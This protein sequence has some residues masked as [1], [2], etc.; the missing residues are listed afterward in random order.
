MASVAHGAR[1]GLAGDWTIVAR[2]ELRDLWL[3]GRGLPLALAF[4]VLLSAIAY[5]GATNEGLNFLER[6]ETVNLVAQVAVAMGAML[7]VLVAADAISG[8]RERG[9]LESLLLTPVSRRGLVAGKLLAALSLW[10]AALVVALPYLWF[11]ARGVGALGDAVGAAL[12]AGTLVAVALA[13]LGLVVSTLAGSNRLSLSVSLFV[14]LALYAPTQLPP[15]AKAGWAGDLLLRVNPVTA[16]EHYIGTVVIDQRGWTQDAA[17]L[18]SPA[19]AAVALTVA[20]LVVVPRLMTLRGSA[21][22]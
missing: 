16:A 22:G 14:L 4:S 10:L 2:Q 5:L 13:A 9:T 21:R 18:L 3:A 20:A 1:G 15:G 6:R 11:L 17:W 7:T 12:I 19:V 8:E